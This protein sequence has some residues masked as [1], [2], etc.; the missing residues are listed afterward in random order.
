MSATSFLDLAARAER[1]KFRWSPTPAPT[2]GRPGGGARGSGPDFAA[3]SGAI[4]ATFVSFEGGHESPLARP[5]LRAL[6]HRSVRTPGFQR[7]P[8]LLR[9]GRKADYRTA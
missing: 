6:G 3:P 1:S 7:A 4:V 2:K 9:G 8:A 5:R